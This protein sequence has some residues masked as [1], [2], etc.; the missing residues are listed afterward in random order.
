LDNFKFSSDGSG[1]TLIIDPPVN[2]TE[3]EGSV[4][5]TVGTGPSGTTTS[6]GLQ[7]SPHLPDQNGLF[8]GLSGDQGFSLK[9]DT[10]HSP[11]SNLS[12]I[13]GILDHL[14]LE[15]PLKS[16]LNQLQSLLQNAADGQLHD[17]S[18]QA[19]GIHIGSVQLS[20]LNYHQDGI[21]HS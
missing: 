4:G 7:P 16:E 8:A 2:S 18:G 6:T 3:N 21:L 11:T 1:G 12:N 9:F 13:S 15:H 10:V 17:L 14:E 5:G 20:H 19:E